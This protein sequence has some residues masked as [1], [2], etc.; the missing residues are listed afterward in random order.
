M[1][2][3]LKL[4][5]WDRYNISTYKKWSRENH[6][7]P[8]HTTPHHIF[9]RPNFSRPN[10]S[11]YPQFSRYPLSQDLNNCSQDFLKTFSRLY[12]DFLKTFSRLSFFLKT[13]FSRHNTSR[14]LTASLVFS[15]F[16]SSRYIPIGDTYWSPEPI[17][18]I[19]AQDNKDIEF[20]GEWSLYKIL[21][22]YI[23]D[24]YRSPDPILENK[25]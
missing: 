21:S 14:L 10:F 12:Q 17:L 20:T 16:N 2:I 9:S 11:R 4:T 18:E 24:T 1:R 15:R 6:T 13:N 8:H 5:Y 22:E 23:G 19:K 25:A 3:A 7:T